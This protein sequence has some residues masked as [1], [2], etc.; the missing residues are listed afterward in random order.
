MHEFEA[1]S[2]VGILRG[3]AGHEHHAVG[4]EAVLVP[5]LAGNTARAISRSKPSVWIVA[6]GSDPAA[7]QGLAFSYGVHPVNL[8]EEPEDWREFVERCLRERDL[9]AERVLLVAGPSKRNPNANHRIELMRLS[10]S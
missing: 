2:G 5:T 7:C 1:V 9:T 10:A 8:A 6:P 4:G 3:R